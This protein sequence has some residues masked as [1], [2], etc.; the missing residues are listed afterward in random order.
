MKKLLR[1][2]LSY[3]LRRCRASAWSAEGRPVHREV[4]D[5]EGFANL[6]S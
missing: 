1:P 5:M 2:L 4:I 6:V 3:A